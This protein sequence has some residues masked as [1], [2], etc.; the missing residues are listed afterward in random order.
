MPSRKLNEPY[1]ASVLKEALI[2][3][4]GNSYLQVL[5]GD[6]EIIL[7]GE[8]VS[9]EEGLQI[10]RDP[11]SNDIT[12]PIGDYPVTDEFRTAE[13]DAYKGSYLSLTF[14][15]NMSSGTR[16]V[17]YDGAE[18][19]ESSVSGTIRSFVRVTNTS[20]VLYDQFFSGV[21][22]SPVSAIRNAPNLSTVPSSS[23]FSK[24]LAS[25]IGGISIQS[26]TFFRGK[27]AFKRKPAIGISA[28]FSPFTYGQMKDLI[29]GVENTRTYQ[30]DKPNSS[31]TSNGPLF[32]RFVS[33]GEKVDP[34]QTNSVNLTTRGIIQEPF[35]DIDPPTGSLD[36]LIVTL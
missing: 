27:P 30:I 2:H 1:V 34:S 21:N 36:T 11:V 24:I 9:D 25:R 28:K 35:F 18:R 16:R 12:T 20:E 19:N 26:G 10:T 23:L 3:F 13:T 7:V 22:E 31:K 32:V 15:G 4:A 17:L 14:T 29:G 33:G 6:A 8:Y 5:P